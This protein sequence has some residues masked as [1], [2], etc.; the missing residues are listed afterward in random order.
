MS[1]R[2]TARG[3]GQILL[4]LGPIIVFVGAFNIFN[5]RDPDNAIYVATA[6]FMA[7]T[8][9]AAGVAWLR[10]RAVPP[11]LIV[12]LALVLAF[13]GLTLALHDETLIKMKPT[14]VYLFYSAAI[15]GAMAFG[16]NVWKLLFSHAF[17]LPD[18]V[19]KILAIRWGL[20]F[21]FMGGLNEAIR[22]TQTTEVWV[23]SR[24]VIGFPLVGLFMLLNLPLTL[25]NA[26]RT[27]ERRLDRE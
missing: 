4:D 17:T 20:F 22:L 9:L 26:G 27:D 12:T 1:A 14:F 19:W 13:G 8:A 11:V 21:I 10:T 16:M 3:A 24:L 25:K 23:N 7:A 15:F 5:R 6:I 18:R 2:E